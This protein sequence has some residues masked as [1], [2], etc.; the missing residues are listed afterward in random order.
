MDFITDVSVRMANASQEVYAR[1]APNPMRSCIIEGCL[2][3]GR[4][5]TISYKNNKNA[6]TLKEGEEGFNAKKAPT[7]IIKGKGN[8]DQKLTVYF[9][10]QPRDITDLADTGIVAD[11]MV[12]EANGK[13]QKKT[14]VTP[15]APAWTH[16]FTL[17]GESLPSEDCISAGQAALAAAESL[18]HLG[19]E[20]P[21]SLGLYDTAILTFRPDEDAVP[22]AW[23]IHLIRNA[24]ESSTIRI[25]AGTGKALALFSFE[26][27]F[28][29]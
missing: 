26:G 25:H 10:I 23:T 28:I 22:S 27:A 9:T 3:K 20:T 17:A 12:V 1:Y 7:M 11:D 13:V 2:E 21:E 16:T 19:L 29:L 15:P 5:Y 6:Y 18:V 24:R 8:Y 14:P 4:D